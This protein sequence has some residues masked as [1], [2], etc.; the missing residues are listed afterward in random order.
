MTSSANKTDR[1]DIT[2]ILF[3]VALKDQVYILFPLIGTSWTGGI[4]AFHGDFVWYNNNDD[5][6]FTNYNSGEPNN[7]SGDENCLEIRSDNH[8]TWNDVDC[9]FFLSFICEK[10]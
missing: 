7:D 9:G 8:G 6:G 10:D 2:E 5:L 4:R 3:K 1:H